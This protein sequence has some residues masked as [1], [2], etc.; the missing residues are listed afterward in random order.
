MLAAY[1]YIKYIHCVWKK[2]SELFL[3]VTLIVAYIFPYDLFT[4]V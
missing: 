3:A 1:T 4:I 2:G